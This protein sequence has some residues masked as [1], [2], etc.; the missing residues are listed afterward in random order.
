MNKSSCLARTLGMTNFLMVIA[1]DTITLC[2][3]TYVELRCSTN[4]PLGNTMRSTVLS[5]PLGDTTL[6]IKGLFETLSIIKFSITTLCHYAEC[7]CAECRILFIYMLIVVAPSP[8]TRTPWTNFCTYF[9]CR[10]LFV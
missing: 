2:C 4:P 9:N 7:H 8:S 5:F 3:A 10:E 1:M 6:S